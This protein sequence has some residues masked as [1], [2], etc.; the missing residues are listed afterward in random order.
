MKANTQTVNLLN[1]V[2]DLLDSLVIEKSIL[3][4]T[5]DSIGSAAYNIKSLGL[6][7]TTYD[8]RRLASILSDD[9][10]E[11]RFSKGFEMVDGKTISIGK[12]TEDSI[13][14]VISNAIALAQDNEYISTEARRAFY[15]WFAGVQEEYPEIDSVHYMRAF[16]VGFLKSFQKENDSE[17]TAKQQNAELNTNASTTITKAQAL[18]LF[19]LL[20]AIESWSFS[21]KFPDYLFDYT[22]NQ[23]NFLTDYILKG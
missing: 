13:N 6:L 4:R 7:S 15:D 14:G 23:L 10:A 17:T 22:E 16:S 3:V 2:A 1:S 20:S 21:T 11:V 19:K 5:D 9:D 12:D 8:I 18:E